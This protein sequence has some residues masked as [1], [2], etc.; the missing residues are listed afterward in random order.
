MCAFY[1]CVPSPS[2]ISTSE[3]RR[4]NECDRASVDRSITL[5]LK[6]SAPL[7]AELQGGGPGYERAQVPKGEDDCGFQGAANPTA[8]KPASWTEP[9]QGIVMRIG[10]NPLMTIKQRG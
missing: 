4:V 9:S 3:R 2:V 8:G 6:K 10:F 7:K 1:Q 5:I